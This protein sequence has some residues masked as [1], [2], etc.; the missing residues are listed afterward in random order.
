MSDGLTLRHTTVYELVRVK[1]TDGRPL[2][3][4]WLEGLYRSEA[5]AWAAGGTQYRRLNIVRSAEKVVVYVV[6]DNDD[7]HEYGHA[8]YATATSAEQEKE[9]RD[10]ERWSSVET[11]IDVRELL[12]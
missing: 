11:R 4:E 9:R 10:S 5:E 6:V 1:G 8:I 12:P 7:E 2:P 3:S